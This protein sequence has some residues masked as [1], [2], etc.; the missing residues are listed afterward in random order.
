MAT[1]VACNLSCSYCY[2]NPLREG[3]NGSIEKPDLDAMK[4]SLEASGGNFTLFGGEAL[5][6]PLDKLTEL[7]RWGVEE[8]K[9]RVGIQTNGALIT[10]EHIALFLKFKVQVGISVDGPAELNDARWAGSLTKTRQATA[11]TLG[12]IDRL[13][14]QKHPPSLIVTLHRGNLAPDR[15]RTFLA[16]LR[17]MRSKG[18]TAIRLHL[19]EVDHEG[20]AEQLA[21]SREDL[22]DA[23]E[24]LMELQADPDARLQFDLFREIVVMQRGDDS[25]TS[26]VYHACDVQTTRAVDAVGPDGERRNCGRV[27]KDGVPWVKAATVGYERQLALHATPQAHG[28]CQGCRFFAMC[29][30]HCPGD[31]VERD[32]RNRSAHCETL[33]WLFERVESL[34]TFMGETPFSK[35]PKREAVEAY[36]LQEWSEGRNRSLAHAIN[37]VSGKV[38]T[39]APAQR[40][41]THGDRPHGDSHGDSWT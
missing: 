15:L 19:M 31:A 24:H 8:R 36:L 10:D 21:L 34:M 33:K 35:H 20:V 41:T 6:L 1:G 26:C 17:K 39:P 23:L 2:Q 4:K 3:G 11:R 32:W 16:W 18:V 13:C 7:V 40:T 22:H 27:E 9:V 37:V 5:L 29:K 30:G 28:G 25:R 12:A 14:A 38:T